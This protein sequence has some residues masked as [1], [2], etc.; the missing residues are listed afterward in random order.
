[1]WAYERQ[2]YL[3]W[4]SLNFTTSV[5][6]PGTASDQWQN[7]ENGAVPLVQLAQRPESEGVTPQQLLDGGHH[8]VDVGNNGRYNRKRRYNYMSAIAGTPIPRDSLYSYV[9]SVVL[10]DHRLSNF[11]LLKSCAVP[12]PKWTC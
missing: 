11:S 8:L 1:M 9:A 5:L 3:L 7:K 2:L 6:L 10:L 4:H 12:P